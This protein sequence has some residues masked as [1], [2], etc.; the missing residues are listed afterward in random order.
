MWKR[1]IDIKRS[2]YN[3]FKESDMLYRIKNINKIEIY[4]NCKKGEWRMFFKL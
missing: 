1:S 4:I 2:L 3:T